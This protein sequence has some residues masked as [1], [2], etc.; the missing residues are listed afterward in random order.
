MGSSAGRPTFIFLRVAM[1]GPKKQAKKVA[2]TARSSARSLPPA[3]PALPALDKASPVR[4]D[5]RSTL[6]IEIEIPTHEVGM[7]SASATGA[8]A[9]N[10]RK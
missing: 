7:A 10:E 6:Y 2:V 4:F 5:Q 3:I 1:D 8:N 9:S